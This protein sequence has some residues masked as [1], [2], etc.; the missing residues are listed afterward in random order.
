[1]FSEFI[2]SDIQHGWTPLVISSIAAIISIWDRYK[3]SRDVQKLQD[4]INAGNKE[5]EE[6]KARLSQTQI[7][8]STQWN[9]EFSS[10]QEIWKSIVP[11]RTIAN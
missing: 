6:L 11:L 5:T 3:S 9:A 1:M 7:I 4:K 8:N 10:Y 2:L